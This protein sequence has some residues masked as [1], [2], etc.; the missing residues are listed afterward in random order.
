MF[1]VVLWSLLDQ[2]RV[3]FGDF[4]VP[5]C[6]K[7]DSRKVDEVDVHCFRRDSTLIFAVIAFLRE[8]EFL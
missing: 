3:A 6:N 4:E 7:F 8:K 2:S 1:S 5:I